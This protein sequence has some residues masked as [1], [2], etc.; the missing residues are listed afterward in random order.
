MRQM[1]RKAEE[2]EAKQRY[3]SFKERLKRDVLESRRKLLNV[4]RNLPPGV[5][6]KVIKQKKKINTFCEVAI[7]LFFL[8]DGTAPCDAGAVGSFNSQDEAPLLSRIGRNK[9]QSGRNGFQF[10]RQ[11]SGRAA[12]S[13]IAQT[14]TAFEQH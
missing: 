2:M 12:S 14:K 6:P 3:R 9:S 5:E 7:F 1:I 8:L 10:G 11:L 4:V 13:S